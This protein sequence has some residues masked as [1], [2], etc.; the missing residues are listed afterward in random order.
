MNPLTR[1]NQLNELKDPQH[2]LRSLF[3]R[4]RVRVPEDCVRVAQFI[5]LV[6]VSED[7]R[8]YLIKAALPQG[9][10]EDVKIPLED[11]SV[12]KNGVLEVHLARNE[13]AGHN[14]ANNSEPKALPLFP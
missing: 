10:K 2:T 13:K 14:D 5:P 7:A 11:G 12:F 9:R 3:S 8:G 1:W 6:D 4:S